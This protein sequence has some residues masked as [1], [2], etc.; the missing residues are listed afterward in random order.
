MNDQDFQLWSSAYLYGYCVI[1]PQ[2]GIA[3]SFQLSRGI[4]RLQGWPSDAACKMDDS[5]PKDTDLPDVVTGVGWLVVSARVQALLAS[6]KVA[7]VEYL[8][9]QILNHKGKLA[10]KDYFIVNPIGQVDCVDVAASKVMWNTINPELI[11]V[12]A[13]L[14]LRADAVP[15][16]LSI[17]RPKHLPQHIFVRTSLAQRLAQEGFL[18][19]HFRDPSTFNGS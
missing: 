2:T 15:H 13:S 11:S 9:L 4:S 3:K 17:F 14:V 8:P 10:A 12:C 16:D 6:L 18:G 1:K 7:S 19:L 5:F